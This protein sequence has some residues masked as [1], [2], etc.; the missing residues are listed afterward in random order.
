MIFGGV[1]GSSFRRSG[2]GRLAGSGGVGCRLRSGVLRQQR[3]G[4]GAEGRG[5]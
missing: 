1:L 3:G 5:W 2:G 4:L